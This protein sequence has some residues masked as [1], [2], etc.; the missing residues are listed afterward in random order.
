MEEDA[1]S[2]S[3]SPEACSSGMN[4][5]AEAVTAGMEEEDWTAADA[6]PQPTIRYFTPHHRLL[7]SPGALAVNSQRMALSVSA[8]TGRFWRGAVALAPLPNPEA[9]EVLIDV[10]AVCELP[11]GVCDLS[12]VGHRAERI[13]TGE[14]KKWK[15]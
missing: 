3:Q 9:E 6:V 10:E 8:L 14:Q 13:L 5:S 11:S 12:F 4:G 1:E 15:S 2:E 7:P